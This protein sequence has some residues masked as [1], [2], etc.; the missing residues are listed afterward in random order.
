MTIFFGIDPGSVYTGFGVVR[1]QG[2]KLV[3]VDSGRIV[4]GRSGVDDFGV[5]LVQIHGDLR[6]LLAQ[7]R[8]HFVALEKIFSHVNVASALKLGQARGVALLACAQYSPGSVHEYTPRAV[9]KGMTGYGA[10]TKDQMQ[11]MVQKLLGLDCALS[12]DAA[13]ALALA[14]YCASQMPLYEEIK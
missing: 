2:A 13:D 4:A 6:D 1:K 12:E 8:P 5:R 10:A 7:H 14:M 11:Y 9:K 3:H